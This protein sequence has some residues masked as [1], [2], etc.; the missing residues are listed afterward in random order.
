MILY[1]NF[2]EL[3]AISAGGHRLVGEAT[4]GDHPVIAPPQGLV[5]LEQLLPRLVGDIEIAT[6][7]D[8]RSI[9]RALSYLIAD[10]GI[11]MD[12][13]I[14]SQHPAAE[15]AVLAYFDY[16]HVRATLARIDQMGAEMEAIIE[17]ATGAPADEA[18]ARGFSFLE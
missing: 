7:H 4:G 18:A 5:D 6:L 16:A 9:R 11:R 10:L 14:V 2:E 12:E 13:A 1:C 15:D 8:L 17:L 3:A